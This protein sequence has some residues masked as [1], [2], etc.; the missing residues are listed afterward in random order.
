MKVIAVSDIYC[1]QT[2]TIHKTMQKVF[3]SDVAITPGMDLEDPN[4]PDEAV[5]IKGVLINPEEPYMYLTLADEPFKCA[6]KEACQ[7]RE[8]DLRANG[9]RSAS[10]W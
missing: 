6:S 9:W 4:W 8:A 2:N 3:S 10:E 1:E 5:C 7:K